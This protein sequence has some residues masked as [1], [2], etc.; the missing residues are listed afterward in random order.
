M[1][2]PGSR[3]KE[4]GAKGRGWDM[5]GAALVLGGDCVVLPMNDASFEVHEGEPILS[6]NQFG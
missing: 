3:P 5:D 6:P 2:D 1:S 4:Q